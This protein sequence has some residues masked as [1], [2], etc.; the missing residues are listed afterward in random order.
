MIMFLTASLALAHNI[1]TVGTCVIL[2]APPEPHTLLIVIANNTDFGIAPT[3]TGCG[4]LGEI[5]VANQD[6]VMKGIIDPDTD[7]FMPVIPERSSPGRPTYRWM[8]APDTTFVVGGYKYIAG[9]DPRNLTLLN[10]GG[11]AA[12]VYDEFVKPKGACGEQSYD[13]THNKTVTFGTSCN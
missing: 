6:L 3:F 7:R 13:V 5:Q 1:G 11:V 10:I 4:E 9:F 12:W 2:D 8:Y